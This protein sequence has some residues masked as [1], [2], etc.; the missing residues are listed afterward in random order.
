MYLDWGLCLGY[1]GGSSLNKRGIFVEKSNV[2]F[3][4]FGLEKEEWRGDGAL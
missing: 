1:F 2:D 3:Y 4:G